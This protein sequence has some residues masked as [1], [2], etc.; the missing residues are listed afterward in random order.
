MLKRI[1]MITQQK[2]NTILNSKKFKNIH[3][4]F[5]DCSNYFKLKNKAKKRL[6]FLIDMTENKED[7]NFFIELLK[8]VE[9][10]TDEKLLSNISLY[11]K[12]M[13]E[14][15]I[16]K[17]KLNKKQEDAYNKVYT[18]LMEQ[19]QHK[20]IK[21]EEWNNFLA[22]KK[23]NITQHLL[24][25]DFKTIQI[26]NKLE[27]IDKDGKVGDIFKKLK[28]VKAKNV[29]SLKVANNIKNELLNLINKD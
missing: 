7:R 15:K 22:N 11:C 19:L 10:T 16:K 17:R 9:N 27:K 4:N 3:N 24:G 25:T 28:N 21:K 20:K 6:N 1:K 5:F 23:G 2:L 26:Q 8:V 13:Y 14:I 12:F 29:K 18:N